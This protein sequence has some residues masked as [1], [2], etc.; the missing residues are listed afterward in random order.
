M[1]FISLSQDPF[2][3]HDSCQPSE[4]RGASDRLEPMNYADCSGGGGGMMSCIGCG[5]GGNACT[6]EQMAIDRNVGF[7]CAT[8]VVQR[9]TAA[10]ERSLAIGAQRNDGGR[11]QPAGQMM[12]HVT[13]GVLF[14][15]TVWW[16]RCVA[17]DLKSKG[18]FDGL[19]TCGDGKAEVGCWLC[20][21]RYYPVVRIQ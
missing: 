18:I 11:G 4:C 13:R 10:S 6:R 9:C 12:C 7:V 2:A 1:S 5:A 15:R 3:W 8:A 17:R 14:R 20:T 16:L 21:V 19:F